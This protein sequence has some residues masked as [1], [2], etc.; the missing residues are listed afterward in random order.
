MLIPK[1]RFNEIY[2]RSESTYVGNSPLLHAWL[3]SKNR[4]MELQNVV[5]NI[6]TVSDEVAKIVKDIAAA[7]RCTETL[8]IESLVMAY[9]SANDLIPI[10][11][12]HTKTR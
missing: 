3:K 11:R 7:E 4:E 6:Y 5:M 9:A 8:V 12:Q 10:D 1:N 2:N